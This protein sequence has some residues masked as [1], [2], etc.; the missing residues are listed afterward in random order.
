[1][2][3]LSCEMCGSPNLIKQDGL[4]VCQNCGTKYSVEEARKMMIDGPVDVSGSTVNIDN[5]D[6][7]SN[8]Y[9][10]ARR[11]RD[12]NNAE[13]AEKYY[14]MILVEDPNSWEASFYVVYFNAMQCKIAE[15]ASA[16]NS[17]RNC[18]QSVISLIK[19]GC[20]N[21]DQNSAVEEVVKRCIIISKYLFTAA[22]NRYYEIDRRNSSLSALQEYDSE[23]KRR[24]SSSRDIMYVC[25]DSIDRE[26]G[27]NDVIIKNAI[28]AWNSGIELHKT[29]ISENKKMYKFYDD[30]EDLAVIDSYIK[31]TAKYDKNLDLQLQI[32][33]LEKEVS[34]LQNKIWTTSD[35]YTNNRRKNSIIC[36][37]VGIL[38]V[39]LGFLVS[40]FFR[41]VLIAFGALI[42]FA[43]F[44]YS[45]EINNKA[46]REKERLASEAKLKEK[47]AI[48]NDLKKKS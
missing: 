32:D 39:I 34:Y 7:L 40:G 4:F 25:G 21:E 30:K 18:L 38:F 17:V 26:F 15:I 20:P 42:V 44:G 14:Q 47:Q 35:S 37:V 22:T 2:K 43:G 36:F 27:N 31:K 28:T 48:L 11:F 45:G 5:S 29:F 24:M 1:M 13:N 16:A 10:V 33:A 9:Q 8:L 12:D 46:D 6:K 23:Y 3:Q 19:T 41:F